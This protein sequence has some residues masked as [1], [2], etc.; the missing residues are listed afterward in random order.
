MTAPA[1]DRLQFARAAQLEKA[2][3]ILAV[4]DSACTVV[5]LPIPR[6]DAGVEWF[7][8]LHAV[9]MLEIRWKAKLDRPPSSETIA[10]LEALIRGRSY[11]SR[12]VGK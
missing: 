7:R 11:A 1:L 9:C 5:D 4:I 12:K 3:K 8:S 2:K 10:H 6:G